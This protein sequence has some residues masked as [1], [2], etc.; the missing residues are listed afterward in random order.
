MHGGAGE[1]IVTLRPEEPLPPKAPPIKQKRNFKLSQKDIE[2]IESAI[3]DIAYGE[4]RLILCDKQI[5]KIIAEDHKMSTR[6]L[7]KKH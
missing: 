2:W 7:D 4:V 1:E 6:T 5:V 3:R